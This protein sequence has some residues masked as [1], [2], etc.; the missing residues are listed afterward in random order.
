M[1]DSPVL[2]RESVALRDS[3]SLRESIALCDRERTRI[4][5]KF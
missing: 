2:A 3:V 5:L 1:Y 4:G